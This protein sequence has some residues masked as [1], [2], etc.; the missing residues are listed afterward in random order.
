MLFDDD[1]EF[2]ETE[3]CS[4]ESLHYAWPSFPLL[5]SRNALVSGTE[6]SE[7]SIW[8][9]YPCQQASRREPLTL[10]FFFFSYGSFQTDPQKGFLSRL[11]WSS[12]QHSKAGLSNMLAEKAGEQPLS[13]A[14]P[15]L[16]S[17]YGEQCITLLPR[18]KA[19]PRTGCLWSLI[20]TK[21]DL[22]SRDSWFQ[23]YGDVSIKNNETSDPEN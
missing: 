19:K 10:T 21:G 6:T 7:I 23:Y 1:D 3:L 8:G 2:L 18:V 22:C 20:S 5:N 4:A 15:L 13:A 12:W 9:E 14:G 16:K 11:L 17:N